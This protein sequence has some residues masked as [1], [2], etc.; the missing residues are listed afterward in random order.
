[1]KKSVLLCNLLLVGIVLNAQTNP[2]I[3]KCSR[4]AIGTAERCNVSVIQIGKVLSN[5]IRVYLTYLKEQVAQE[6]NFLKGSNISY[7]DTSLLY[8][9]VYILNVNDKG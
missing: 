9:G 6:K 1:M 2:V 8:G 7:F 4:N 5:D 3:L